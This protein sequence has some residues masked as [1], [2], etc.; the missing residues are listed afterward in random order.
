MDITQILA[1]LT[2]ATGTIKSIA[3]T[4]GVNLLPYASTVANAARVLEL[5]AGA[6]QRVVD[7]AAALKATFEGHV[8]TQEELDALDVQIAELEAEVDAP[9]PPPEP[10][11]KD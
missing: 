4:P 3:E 2:V 11:E 10:G 5:A 9:L 1:A 6:G 7:A 8:P